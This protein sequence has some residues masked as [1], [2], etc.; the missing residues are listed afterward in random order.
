MGFPQEI[1]EEHSG[2]SVWTER[3]NEIFCHLRSP[4]F[5][6]VETFELSDYSSQL[7]TGQDQTEFQ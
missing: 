7:Y 6:G 4:P 1:N 5:P 3:R 2:L